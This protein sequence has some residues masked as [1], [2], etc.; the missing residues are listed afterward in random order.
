[1]TQTRTQAGRPT[2]KPGTMTYKHSACSTSD[3]YAKNTATSAVAEPHL[4]VIGHLLLF[5]LPA[6]AALAFLVLPVSSARHHPGHGLLVIVPC[7]A[8]PA[9]VTT[10]HTGNDYD[11]KVALAIVVMGCSSI[12]SADSCTTTTSDSVLPSLPAAPS[13]LLPPPPPPVVAFI[14]ISPPPSACADVCPRL[15]VRK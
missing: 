3:Y 10:S 11:N 6:L 4:E 2:A 15:P 9:T 13:S 7:V 12:A 1:M 8:Q 14:S 5:L